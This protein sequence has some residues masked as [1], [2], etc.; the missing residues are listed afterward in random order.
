MIDL[1]K[2]AE[3]R[4]LHRSEGLGIKTIARRLG[5]ARNT[6][7]AALAS[8]RPPRYERIAAGS[9]AD[10]VEPEIAAELRKDPLMPAAEIGRRIGWVRWESVLRGQGREDAAVV[11][12]TG[13]DGSDGLRAG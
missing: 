4:R 5:V 3:I 9:I 11:R 2:W 6:V 1:G 7:R 10:A 12:A 8:D 13:P